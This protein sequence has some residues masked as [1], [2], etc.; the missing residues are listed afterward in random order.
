[1]EPS[2]ARSREHKSSPSRA[3]NGASGSQPMTAHPPPQPS[4][5]DVGASAGAPP[6]EGRSRDAR[7]DPVVSAPVTHWTVPQRCRGRDRPSRVCSGHSLDRPAA[8]LRENRARALPY[9]GDC[10][11]FL[12]ASRGC[13]TGLALSSSCLSPPGSPLTLLGMCWPH[14][15]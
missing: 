14:Y 11:H 3:A 1:M 6:Q 12:Q 2:C 7:T 9:K 4:C 5:V 10:T 15:G 13:C 8:M